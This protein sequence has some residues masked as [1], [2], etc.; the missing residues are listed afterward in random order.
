MFCEEILCLSNIEEEGI[1]IVIEVKYP[2]GGDL[3][4]GCREALAQIKEKGYEEKLIQDGMETIL[5]YGIA[6]CRKQCRVC[7][8]EAG[9]AR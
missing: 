1:G 7:V 5:C 4:A 3:E 6:C 8:E 9:T 2:D